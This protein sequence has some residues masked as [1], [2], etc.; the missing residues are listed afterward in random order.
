MLEL[1]ELI[2][3][4]VVPEDYDCIGVGIDNAGLKERTTDSDDTRRN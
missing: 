3:K 1:P 2:V 4:G